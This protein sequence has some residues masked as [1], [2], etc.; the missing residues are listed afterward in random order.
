[1]I[2]SPD[3][4]QDRRRRR[5]GGVGDVAQNAGVL[6]AVAT[7][8]GTGRD[9]GGWLRPIAE[10]GT[11]AGE[12]THVPDLAA[13]VSARESAE[14]PRWAWASTA[15][16]YPRLLR[17]GVQVRRCQDLEL[18]EALLLGHDGRWGEPRSLAAL[19]ARLRGAPVPP[20]LDTGTAPPGQ[21]TLFDDL[22][23]PAVL[24]DAENP[25][26]AIWT[27][28]ADQRGRIGLTAHPQRFRLLVAVESAGALAAAEMGRIGL[29]WRADVHDDL[30]TELL[31]PNPPGGGMPPRLVGLK[32]KISDSFGGGPVHPESPADLLRAFSR[33]GIVLPSTRA[34]V[35]QG[36]DH[37]AVPSL[38][39]FKE[40]YR[41]WTA[42][43]W[44]WRVQWVRDARFRPEYVP[45]GVVSG[46]W[47]SR[48]GGALQIPKVVRRAVVADEGWRLVVA[49]AG[50]LEPR[51]LA[52]MAGDEGLAAAGRAGDLYRALADEAFGGDRSRA[53]VALL[54]AMY[55]Q[56][57]GSAVP[58]LAALRARFPVAWEFVERAAREGEGGGLVRSWL[59][60]T[61]PPADG[62]LSGEQAR[63][64][65]RFTRNFVVQA[66]AAEW[67]LA[68]LATVRTQLPAPAQ[69]VFFQHDEI[70]VHS[71]A[72]LAPEVAQAVHAAGETA[73]RLLFGE[74]VVRFPLDVSTVDCYADA[75]A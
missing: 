25:V 32:E 19:V 1:M 69:L 52:A 55:G 6:V 24:R 26:D 66:T 14:A 73:T 70:M 48:G 63:A 41:L 56:T 65:G 18:T 30:L 51:V 38:L 10:D 71:P 74:T 68:L 29:P 7:D 64:R 17:A 61:C 50:Q 27:G 33:A 37:P 20:D 40:L 46:R 67:A 4:D 21:E 54:G 34:W 49:D 23:P 42:H 5:R 47:A 9:A 36:V 3:F 75:K 13:A 15:G 43:G 2:E 53:K 35:L 22:P 39:E 44:S 57:G 60:R 12:A 45:G 31:G 28:Y 72:E 16:L 59:G 58:A 62:P 8:G 11:P